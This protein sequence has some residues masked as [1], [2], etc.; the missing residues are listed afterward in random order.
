MSSNPSPGGEQ[1][2]WFERWSQRTGPAT[3]LTLYATIG[4]TALAWL[5]GLSQALSNCPLFTIQHLE[6]YR[7]LVSWIIQGSLLGFVFF[8]LSFGQAGP[9]S[10]QSLGSLPTLYLISIVSVLSSIGHALLCELLSIGYKV[11]TQVSKLLRLLTH[12]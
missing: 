12:M 9:K 8:I 2:S 4:G 11:R 6:L 7:L 10:E 1:E 5:L 3:R